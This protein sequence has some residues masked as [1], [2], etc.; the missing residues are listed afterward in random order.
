MWVTL[1]YLIEVI[2]I[3]HYCITNSL[4]T[5]TIKGHFFF[6][7][8]RVVSVDREPGGSLAVWFCLRVSYE[9]SVKTLAQCLLYLA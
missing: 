6:K 3:I 2:L 7:L 4:K 8:S 5:L 1:I 9:V